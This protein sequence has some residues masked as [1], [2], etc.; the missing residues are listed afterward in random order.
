MGK[1]TRSN[2]NSSTGSFLTFWST[3]PGILTGVAALI[4]ALVGLYIAL[5]PRDSH[6]NDTDTKP[7]PYVT[8]T[9]APGSGDC[10]DKEFAKIYQVEVGSGGQGIA[11]KDGVL[12]IKLSENRVVIGALRLRFYREG[13]YFELEEVLD[14]QCRPV[15]GL[16]NLS[17]QSP[18]DTN[19]KPQ[20]WDTLQIPLGSHEYSLRLGCDGGNCSADFKKL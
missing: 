20:N 6:K 1:K 8:P 2:A 5:G 10:F 3:L 19:N 18:V 11:S 4:T 17:R 14:A 13:D 16:R 12:R 9:A 15:E 7:T